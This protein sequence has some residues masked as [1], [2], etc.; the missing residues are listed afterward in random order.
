MKR[1]MQDQKYNA[2][3]KHIP[4]S[5]DI[6]ARVRR[7]PRIWFDLKIHL[8]QAAI[9]NNLQEGLSLVLLLLGLGAL[10]ISISLNSL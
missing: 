5:T 7:L 6:L 1:K 2:T 9:F 3:C 8:Q 4:E 10:P